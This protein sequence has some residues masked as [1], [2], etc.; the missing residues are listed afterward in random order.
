V[1]DRNGD[2]NRDR[3]DR[4]VEGTGDEEV[5]GVAGRLM[6]WR[7]LSRGQMGDRSYA[8]SLALTWVGLEKPC[9]RQEMPAIWKSGLPGPFC[10]QIGPGFSMLCTISEL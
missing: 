9:I 3:K 2:V 6:L 10:P 1:R 4:L 7:L 8:K 5:C